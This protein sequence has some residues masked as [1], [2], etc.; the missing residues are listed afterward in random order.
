MT[1]PGCLAPSTK[2]RVACRPFTERFSRVFSFFEAFFACVIC[3]RAF[4]LAVLIRQQF[5][6]PTG[7]VILRYGCSFSDP[8]STFGPIFLNAHRAVDIS[9]TVH[10]PFISRKAPG[11]G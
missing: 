2:T 4:A 5:D 3:A 7:W 10:A 8:P 6:A 9:E 1:G 11:L